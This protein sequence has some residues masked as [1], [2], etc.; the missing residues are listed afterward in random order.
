MI[1]K[2][3][4]LVFKKYPGKHMG[5]IWHISSV[6]CHTSR[7]SELVDYYLQSEVKKLK[8]YVKDTT[9]FIKKI[10]AIDHASDDSYVVSLDVRS[11]YTNI[12]HKKG[13]EA[14]NQK[15]KKPKPSINIKVVLTF[16]KL[17]YF[18]T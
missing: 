8:S 4:V 7:I 10:E 9:D 5:C 13:I 12:L 17:T 16:L 18:D 1:I 2:N 3:Q 15:L 6:N 14:D 11:L